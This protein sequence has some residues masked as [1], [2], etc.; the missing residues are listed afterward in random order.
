MGRQC[1]DKGQINFSFKLKESMFRLDVRKKLFTQR[2]V[3]HWNRFSKRLWMPHLSIP[4]SV[5][6]QAG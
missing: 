6:D 4:E 1:Q 5:P 2:V 3:K